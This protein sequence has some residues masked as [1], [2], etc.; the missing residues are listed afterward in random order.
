MLDLPGTCK[1]L[2]VYACVDINTP[3]VLYQQWAFWFMCFS[4]PFIDS[5][6]TYRNVALTLSKLPAWTGT[7]HY[8]RWTKQ[9]HRLRAGSFQL[10]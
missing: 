4:V 9:V 3:T 5:S 10:H 8:E 6:F 1:Y 2:L 7:I